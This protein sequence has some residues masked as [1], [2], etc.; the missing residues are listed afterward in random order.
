MFA[1]STGD[2]MGEFYDS[3]EQCVSE[4]VYNAKSAFAEWRKLS[5]YERGKVLKRAASL[6]R[7]TVHH[8]AGNFVDN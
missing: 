3:S 8:D 5:A 7:V 4:A 2:V 1:C 6:I